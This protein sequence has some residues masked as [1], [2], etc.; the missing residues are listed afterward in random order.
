[1]RPNSAKSFKI[2]IVIKYFYKAFSFSHCPCFSVC[3]KIKGSALKATAAFSYTRYFWY[4]KYY[5][6]D[7][8]FIKFLV[9]S[10]DIFCSCS[11]L[12]VCVMRKPEQLQ[13]ISW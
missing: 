10:H 4:G 13:K 7:C 9:L 8:A 3:S 12:R 2:A 6:R 1:M 5:A 11:G